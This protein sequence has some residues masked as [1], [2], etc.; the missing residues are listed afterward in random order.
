[1]TI[2]TLKQGIAI[3]EQ[4]ESNSTLLSRLQ[5]LHQSHRISEL[6]ASDIDIL[7][8]MANRGL[9]LEKH[10]LEHQLEKL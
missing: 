3:K 2:E 1:M 8:D 7:I 6:T 9:Q 10:N 4:M 5:K